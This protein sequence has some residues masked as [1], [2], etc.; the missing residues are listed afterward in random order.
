MRV[1]CAPRC[2]VVLLV[3]GAA[4]AESAS[5][6]SVSAKAN[7]TTSVSDEPWD[8]SVQLERDGDL[9]GAEAVLVAAWGKRPD[10]FYAQ[11]RLAY[12]ALIGKR[13]NAA[14]AR[15]KRAR[16]FPEAEGDA[17]ALAGYAAALALKGWKLA[18]AG[19]SSEAQD[20]WHKALAVQPDQPDALTGLETGLVPVT[21]PE[22]WGALAGQS[23]GSGR[24]QGLVAFAQIPWRFFDRLTLRVAG[25]HI[26]WRQESNLS[27]WAFPGQSSARWTVNEIYGGAGYDTPSATV[28]GLGFAVT[29]AAIPTLSGAGVRARVGRGWGASADVA[30]LRSGGRW[31]NQQLRPVAFLVIGSRVVLNAGARLTREDGDLR[32]SGVAGVSL[33]GGPLAVFVQGHLGAEHW[34]ANLASPSVLSITPRTSSGTSLT[35]LWNA[36][37]ALRVAGQAEAYALAADG[38]TGTFW[39]VSLGLQLRVFSL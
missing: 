28:E 34:A 3:A 5:V 11:L 29:S 8:R 10:N 13:A 33:L 37:H 31:V 4:R 24:S 9:R 19:R 39:S 22:V 18:D 32:A 14:V 6:D 16:R 20:V 15:Y 27:P 12:L 36:T 30:A 1:S 25:R 26:D 21:E 17:D 35:V 23:F 2:L 38:A 7:V